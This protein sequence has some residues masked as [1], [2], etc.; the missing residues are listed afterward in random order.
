MKV[1]T[2]KITPA[3]RFWGFP[4]DSVDMDLENS[5]TTE[6]NTYESEE[7]YQY[8]P[9]LFEKLCHKRRNIAEEEL[10][11]ASRVLPRDLLKEMATQLPQTPEEFGQ[12]KGHRR[13]KDEIR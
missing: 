6:L 2:T 13:S 11:Q 10:I 8:D 7:Q 4:V 5:V 3:D 12:I 9:G 1:N